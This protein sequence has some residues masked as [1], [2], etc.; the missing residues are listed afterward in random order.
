MKIGIVKPDYKINGGFEVVIN[1]IREEL[2]RAGHQ[3]DIVYVDATESSIKNIPFSV[4]LSDYKQ[5][6]EFFNYIN[7]FWGYLRMDL[8]NYDA[9]ISTQPPS[10]AIQH[11]KHIA[12]FYHHSKIHYDLSDLIQEVGLDKPFHKKAQEVIRI[13]DSISLSKVSTILAGSK[14]IKNRIA[15]YNNLSKNVDLFYAGIDNEIY[16]YNGEISYQAPIVVGR[17]EFPK[18]PELFVKAMKKIPTI[19]GRI[20]GEGGR[21]NDLKKIDQLLTYATN[22]KIEVSDDIVWKKLSNGFFKRNN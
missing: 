8:S 7:Y 9:I 12:L 21:T 20:I 2:E 3:V 14:T 15:K 5:N 1:H 13:I 22:H 11:P 17:H 18:R 6:T 10:F 19:R 4:G 16:N